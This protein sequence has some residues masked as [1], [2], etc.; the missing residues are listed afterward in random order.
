MGFLM[1]SHFCGNV[2]ADQPAQMGRKQAELCSALRAVTSA[3]NGGNLCVSELHCLPFC[4]LHP[5]LWV[6]TA[7]PNWRSLVP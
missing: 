4:L 6:N 1:D 2:K 5:C 3:V 7:A